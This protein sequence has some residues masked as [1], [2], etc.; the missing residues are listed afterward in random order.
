MLRYQLFSFRTSQ[1]RYPPTQLL[2]SRTQGSPLARFISATSG[3]QSY[4]KKKT[5][6]LQ[7]AFV[8]GTELLRTDQDT[9]TILT[10][11]QTVE[12]AAKT[13]IMSG[14]K[15]N[16]Q[17]KA[18]QKYL[19]QVE[20][21]L[22]TQKGDAFYQILIAAASAFETAGYLSFGMRSLGDAAIY[23]LGDRDV[24]IPQALYADVL[25]ALRTLGA[26][27]PKIEERLVRTL[28]SVIRE[29][30]PLSCRRIGYLYLDVSK[31]PV[32]DIPNDKILMRLLAQLERTR[33]QYEISDIR[34]VLGFL[35]RTQIVHKPLIEFCITNIRSSFVNYSA[36]EL[37]RSL[38]SLAKLG[39]YQAD[40]I[41]KTVTSFA[42]PGANIT[43]HTLCSFIMLFTTHEL[44]IGNEFGP[45][46][47]TSALE[48]LENGDLRAVSIVLYGLCYY[49]MTDQQACLKRLLENN[50]FPRILDES[51]PKNVTHIINEV[52]ESASREF[53]TE[54]R[55]PERILAAR[56]SQGVCSVIHSFTS[57]IATLLSRLGQTD[58]SFKFSTG[59]PLGP[60]VPHFI[61]PSKN[62]V[63]E[64]RLYHGLGP[65]LRR[66]HF[67]DLGYILVTLS[68]ATFPTHLPLEN[69]ITYIRKLLQKSMDAAKHSITLQ[70]KL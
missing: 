39:Y 53:E 34:G 32:T 5:I 17:P 6:S 57:H 65:G 59:V 56:R 25:E 35:A 46:L 7:N 23:R 22:W 12:C 1:I 48:R 9:D 31:L 3:H 14:I 64:T 27:A 63:L 24:Q 61:N 2:G 26:P 38:T 68:Q 70:H 58:S 51:V 52:I 45:R 41:T 55:I 49:K 47:V 15:N 44:S 40:L 28:H 20:R 62:I 54:I 18:F 10:T 29:L 21:L 30:S 13:A 67:A 66:R 4:N 60:Y 69:Q 16:F 8:S 33:P 37:I 43:L 11:L 42:S 19:A 36:P 50:V